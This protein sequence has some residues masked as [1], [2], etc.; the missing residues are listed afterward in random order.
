MTAFYNGAT[1]T[2]QGGRNS[3]NFFTPCSNAFTGKSLIFKLSD[4]ETEPTTHWKSYIATSL[5]LAKN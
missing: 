3:V 5:D 1:R 2:A 4:K